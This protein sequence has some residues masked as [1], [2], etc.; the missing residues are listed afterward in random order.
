MKSVEQDPLYYFEYTFKT[1]TKI[2]W[3]KDPC[4][5]ALPRQRFY[6]FECFGKLINHAIP[7][8]ASNSQFS[9]IIVVLGQIQ[10]LWRKVS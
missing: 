6:Y 10:D 7:V 5:K 1:Q 3:M 4:S 2:I 9:Y 8:V